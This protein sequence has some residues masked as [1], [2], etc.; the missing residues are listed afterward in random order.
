MHVL[1][2]WEVCWFVLSTH[3]VSAALND[4][5]S[6]IAALT[7]SNACTFQSNHSDKRHY[8]SRSTT[9][10][11]DCGPVN[12]SQGSRDEEKQSISGTRLTT[13]TKLEAAS[14][15]PAGRQPNQLGSGSF[16]CHFLKITNR[17]FRLVPLLVHSFYRVAA[18]LVDCVPKA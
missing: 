10:I 13:L 4:F 5:V 15:L 17:P 14:S 12:Q 9:I 8:F 18:P 1:P 6:M 3:S 2:Y 11:S 16:D 7:V